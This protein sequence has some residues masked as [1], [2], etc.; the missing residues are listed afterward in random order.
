MATFSGEWDLMPINIPEPICFPYQALTFVREFILGNNE[1]GTVLPNGNIVGQDAP[2]FVNDILPAEH[3]PIF[4]GSGVTAGSTVWPSATIAQWDSFIASAVATD[5]AS[6]S[7]SS[8][9]SNQNGAE[10]NIVSYF[11]AALFSA[12]VSAMVMLV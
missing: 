12:F 4:T 3:D 6:S 9:S 8:S 1:N 7:S 11:C 5:P 2:Q 10:R